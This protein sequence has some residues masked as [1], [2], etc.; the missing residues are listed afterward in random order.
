MC[1]TRPRRLTATA[2]TSFGKGY[3][4]IKIIIL[5]YVKAFYFSHLAQPIKIF[6]FRVLHFSTFSDCSFKLS[7]IDEDSLLLYRRPEAWYWPLFHCQRD[8]A[9]TNN[10]LIIFS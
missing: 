7:L 3:F 1:I 10:Q 9:Y 8:W 5:H 2:G 6:Y 4:I